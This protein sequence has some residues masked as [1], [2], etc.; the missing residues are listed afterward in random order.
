MGVV[1]DVNE[2]INLLDCMDHLVDYKLKTIEEEK[3]ITES[4]RFNRVNAGKGEYKKKIDDEN[5]FFEDIRFRKIDGNEFY[6]FEQFSEDLFN[7]LSRSAANEIIQASNA[8]LRN[9]EKPETLFQKFVLH[10]G[11]KLAIK[12]FYLHFKTL[13]RGETAATADFINRLV[14]KI[15]FKN[16]NILKQV[17]T[18]SQLFNRILQHVDAEIHRRMKA[19]DLDVNKEDF[20]F[21]RMFQFLNS[22]KTLN[23][24]E[25][26]Y[27][28]Y[29]LNFVANPDTRR[30]LQKMIL[31]DVNQI[32]DILYIIQ[33]FDLV[34]VALY[35]RLTLGYIEKRLDT[36]N[37]TVR[38]NLLDYYFSDHKQLAKEL[39][40]KKKPASKNSEKPENESDGES[41]NQKQAAEK[42]PK[43]APKKPPAEPKATPDDEN[44]PTLVSSSADPP[45]IPIP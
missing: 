12:Y 28:K 13:K 3:E 42:K 4:I 23:V 6:N 14:Q 17:S 40:Y 37:Q 10:F 30:V 1:F 31:A 38:T 45:R 11:Q 35:Y 43:K 16:N 22:I 32:E 25:L 33:N 41:R 8:F 26:F 7:V 15:P 39:G 18:W 24:K 5:Y 2:R 29:L 21:P 36:E 9:K 27:F 44:F 19:G 34:L 20:E